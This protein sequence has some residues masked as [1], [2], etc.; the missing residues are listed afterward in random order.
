MPKHKL[1]DLEQGS[2]AWHEFRSQGWGSSDA[3]IISGH[4]PE[5]WDGLYSLAYR[6]INGTQ[7]V[8]TPEALERIRR[9]QAMEPEARDAYTRLTGN[10]VSPTCFIH[11]TKSFLRAS[12]DGI[13]EDFRTILEIKCSGLKVYDKTLA[14]KIPNYYIPQIMHQLAVVPGAKRCHFWMYEP[15]RGGILF[16][17]LPNKEFMNEL[18]ERED[19]A[20]KRIQKGRRIYSGMFGPAIPIRYDYTMLHPLT[21]EATAI[22]STVIDTPLITCLPLFDKADSIID[23]ANNNG[24]EG[25]PIS[26]QLVGSQTEA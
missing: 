9:G 17:V 20:W 11:P 22:E 8:F 3:N 21:V 7:K 1:I 24:V 10:V 12:L 19:I 25:P 4:L 14:G 18:I 26:T 16:E 13:T 15:E 6:K 2:E 5:N 23:V